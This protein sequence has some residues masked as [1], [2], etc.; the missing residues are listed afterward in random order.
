MSING[1]MKRL[2]C[3]KH[4]VEKELIGVE[5]GGG[6]GGGGGVLVEVEG[7]DSISVIF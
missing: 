7:L 6:V 4:H 5:G 2:T 1:L 3:V